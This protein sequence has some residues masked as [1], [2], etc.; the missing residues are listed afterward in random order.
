M[1]HSDNDILLS[2]Y[3]DGELSA[4]EQARVEQ[5][6]ATS[7]EARQIV[8]ELRTL[9]TSLQELPRHKLGPGF[10]EQ[11]RR[12][13]EA[14]SRETEVGSR[15]PVAGQESGVATQ[16]PEL[17]TA[18]RPRLFNRRGIAWSIV[19]IA[20]ALLLLVTN[21][22]ADHKP[23]A[24]RRLEKESVAQAP[25]LKTNEENAGAVVAPQPGQH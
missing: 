10:A 22:P 23:V 2:A 13:A 14:E 4:A 1:D 7:A 5:L 20:A 3:L 24:E 6:L 17:Q 18:H 11:V 8:D 16:A 12:R 25:G 21:R 9:R 19:A 15:E